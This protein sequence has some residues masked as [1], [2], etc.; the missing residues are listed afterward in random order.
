M[1]HATGPVFHGLEV[2]AGGC[3]KSHG[4]GGSRATAAATLRP[5]GKHVL[6]HGQAT[7]H[8]HR[9][10]IQGKPHIVL[11][12]SQLPL[13]C[14]QPLLPLRSQLILQL[15]GC[16][17]GLFGLCCIRQLLLQLLRWLLRWLL[18]LRLLL[19]LLLLL[20]AVLLP[21][22]RGSNRLCGSTRNFSVMPNISHCCCHRVPS[23]T[24]RLGSGCAAACTR[25][26]G[27]PRLLWQAAGVGKRAISAI[28]PGFLQGGKAGR[29]WCQQ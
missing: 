6:Q 7:G 11:C 19:L 14:L 3:W 21:C 22:F 13:R 16:L 28:L 15:P 25:R 9:S 26:C 18:L 20:L 29:V 12:N 8:I 5:P 23:S 24:A 27:A 2:L 10:L 4:D 1:C 17:C